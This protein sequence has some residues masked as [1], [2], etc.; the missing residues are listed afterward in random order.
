MFPLPIYTM[1]TL[2]WRVGS[3]ALA[4]ILSFCAVLLCAEVALAADTIVP[5]SDERSEG[6]FAWA[7][8]LV[9]LV[10]LALIVTTSFLKISIALT[11]LRSALGSAQV[12]PSSAIL[13]VSVLLSVYIMAP[14]AF[15]T[16]RAAQPVWDEYQAEQSSQPQGGPARVTLPAPS[17]DP[18]G[19]AKDSSPPAFLP[20][21]PWIK[22]V[23]TVLV[24]LHS[25]LDRHSGQAERELFVALGQTL[26]KPEDQAWVRAKS[27]LVLVPAFV[28]T[29]LKEAFIIGFVIYLPFLILDIA[30][31]SILLSLNMHMLN[32][33]SVSLP[34]KLLLFVLMDGW[35]LLVQGLI[36]GYA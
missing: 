7:L 32:P 13:A 1:S 17:P 16:A 33:S 6:G 2:G 29:E 27:W 8:G 4:A 3:V 23:E 15:D 14:V 25:W 9:T 35:T 31:A 22:R 28:L 36:L 10:P 26:Y 20:W 30:V 11:F 12:P 5:A 18:G 34:F 24:P 19:V 21:E